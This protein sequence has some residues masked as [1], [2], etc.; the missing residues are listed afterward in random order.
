MLL[1]QVHKQPYGIFLQVSYKTYYLNGTC[2]TY[3]LGISIQYHCTKSLI[4]MR[5]LNACVH[6]ARSDTILSHIYF[7]LV[8]QISLKFQKLWFKYGIISFL[9][10]HKPT[11][12]TSD[13]ILNYLK[14]IIG[15]A[16]TQKNLKTNTKTLIFSIWI[17]P[18]VLQGCQTMLLH[19]LNLPKAF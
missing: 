16:T 12:V 3:L 14:K 2:I 7:V 6:T 17:C 19:P 15:G 9:L 8:R 5:S 1:F 11:K 10:S 13:F 18:Q 4:V